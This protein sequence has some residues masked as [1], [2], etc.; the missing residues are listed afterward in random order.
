VGIYADS[1]VADDLGLNHLD[2]EGIEIVGEEWGVINAERVAALRPDLIVAEWWPLENAYSGFEEGS[3]T[4]KSA[5][6]KIAPVLGVAQ[7]P[8]IL[9]MIEDYEALAASWGPT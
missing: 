4:D 3:G 5:L 6:L 2:L 8:S 9:K 1:P 7:G